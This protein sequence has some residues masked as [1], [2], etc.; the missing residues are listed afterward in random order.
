MGWGVPRF[1]Y[2]N[3]EQCY[4]GT[5]TL[6]CQSFLMIKN[7][8]KLITTICHQLIINPRFPAYDLGNRGL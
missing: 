6:L 7:A 5:T 1:T 4:K 3:V 2:Q 8:I